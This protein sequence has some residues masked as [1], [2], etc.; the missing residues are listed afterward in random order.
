MSI[1]IIK[2]LNTEELQ[3]VSGGGNFELMELLNKRSL[4]N[5]IPPIKPIGINGMTENCH[6]P[7][8]ANCGGHCHCRCHECH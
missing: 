6:M 2:K 7:H 1:K 5:I 3:I 8:C 4:T